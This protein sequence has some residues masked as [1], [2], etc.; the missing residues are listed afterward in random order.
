MNVIR[1]ID[2]QKKK[3]HKILSIDAEKATDKIHDLFMIKILSTRN[4]RAHL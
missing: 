4:R 1:N 2:S 3:N